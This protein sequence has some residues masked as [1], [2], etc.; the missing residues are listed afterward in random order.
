MRFGSVFCGACGHY[1]NFKEGLMN[2]KE[3]SNKITVGNG[4]TM[5]ATK[6]VGL[7]CKVIQLDGSSL[8]V[9]LYAV[10]YVLDL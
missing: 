9:T 3:I 4:K 10:K 2:I 7:K 1:C 5:T 8:D 6:V